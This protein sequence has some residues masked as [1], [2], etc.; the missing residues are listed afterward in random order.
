[1]IGISIGFHE[2]GDYLGVGFQRPIAL[3]GGIPVMLPRLVDS[4]DDVL[5]VCSGLLLPGGRDI[6]PSHY[7]HDPHPA[8]GTTDPGRDDFEL[9]LVRAAMDRGMP[10]VGICRGMQMLNVALGGTLVQ[11]VG[12]VDDW[13]GHPSDPTLEYWLPVVAT[14]VTQ[15]PMPPHPRHEVVIEPG[16]LLYRAL[17]VERIDVSSFHHQAIDRLAPGLHVTATAEDGVIEALEW[18]EPAGRPFVL[19]VQWHPE[20]MSDAAGPFS[21]NLIERL[22][23]EARGVRVL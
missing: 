6:I 19:L 22:A 15:D 8:L 4:L 20:R 5:G 11:D 21:R 23:A 2:F 9:E 10:I 3:A 17:G 14:S 13:T 12:L 18:E 1:V 7:G 16:S